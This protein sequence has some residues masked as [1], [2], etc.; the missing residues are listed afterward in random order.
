M[1][2]REF[3]EW[4]AYF[5]LRPFG[6]EWDDTRI[7]VLSAQICAALSGKAQKV[8]DHFAPHLLKGRTKQT[9]AE[10]AAMAQ[11]MAAQNKRIAARG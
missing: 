7:A 3:V 11:M 1:S 8:G 6:P 5:D 2:G 4:L 10:V 9:R